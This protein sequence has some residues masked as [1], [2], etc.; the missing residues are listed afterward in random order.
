MD[1]CDVSTSN[2]DQFAL[3]LVCVTLL[4]T[5]P[6]CIISWSARLETIIEF[7]YR[8]IIVAIVV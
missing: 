7:A 5:S 4:D 2:F 8:L 1:S 3:T 6:A